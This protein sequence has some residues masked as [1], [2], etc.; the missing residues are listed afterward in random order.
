M[1]SINK[2]YPIDIDF[3][4][5]CQKCW[6]NDLFQSYQHLQAAQITISITI[7]LQVQKWNRNLDTDIIISDYFPNDQNSKKTKSLL[8]LKLWKSKWHVLILLTA[9]KAFLYND[10]LSWLRMQYFARKSTVRKQTNKNVFK[11]ERDRPHIPRFR[12]CQKTNH[13]V[14]KSSPPR[15]MLKDRWD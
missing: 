12:E 5:L 2:I 10:S 6:G 13:E 11:E 9:S 4:L 8:S 7:R 14:S 15:A 3:L 1:L